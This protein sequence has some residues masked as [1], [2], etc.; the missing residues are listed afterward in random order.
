MHKVSSS[1]VLAWAE[2]EK[3]RKAN[4]AWNATRP[5]VKP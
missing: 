5:G 2:K 4:A 3:K 1:K